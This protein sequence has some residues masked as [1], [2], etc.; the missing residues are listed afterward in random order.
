MA[1]FVAPDT[2]TPRLPMAHTH[3]M[4]LSGTALRT[5]IGL[6]AGLCFVAFGYGQGDIGGLVIMDGFR[7]EFPQIDA[8]LHPTLRVSLLTG[9]TVAMWN[10]GCFFGAMLTVFVGDLCGRK[11]SIT[12]GLVLMISGKIVQVAS[13]SWPQFLVGRFLA[14]FGNGI[15]AST[16]PA[17]QAECLKTHRRGTLLLVSFGSCITAGVAMAYWIDYGFSFVP[18]ESAS[19]RT[20]VG[21]G[22]TFMVPP[23]L[24]IVFL[25]E[26]PRYLVLT[27]REAEAKSVLSALNEDSPEDE[28]IHREFLMIKN[29][30]LHLTSGGVKEAFTMGKYRYLHRTILAVVLQ[31]M[32]QFTGVNLFIQYLGGMFHNQLKFPIPMALLLAGVCSTVFFLASLV[33]VVGIDR[34]WG[35]RTLTMFGAS[36]MCLCM[37]LLAILEHSG[38]QKAHYAMTAFLFL[39]CACFAIGWQGMS[40]LWAVELIPLCTRGPANAL[41][42]AANWLA[43]FAVVMATPAMFTNIHYRI[44]IVFAVTNFCIVPAI[45]FFYPETG[46]RSL[47]EVDVLFSEAGKAGHPWLSVV[48]TA[49][50]EPLWFDRF[51]ERSDSYIS[52]S[53]LRSGSSEKGKHDSQGSDDAAKWKTH[54]REREQDFSSGS[55]SSEGAEGVAQSEAS[56]T[57]LP[58][59]PIKRSRNGV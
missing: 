40:W 52:E 29:T 13:F 51:G 3:Y 9:I 25:P 41:A 17:W 23:L 42:T 56:L 45:Y 7:K 35:R 33:A 57:A 37:T 39:Y 2:I 16:V 22:M 5:A 15:I 24:L 53:G 20:P 4:G 44:Y 46:Y 19:W 21:L 6:T 18:A 34:F 55:G 38:T 48:K 10:L 8:T 50:M 47:E 32:Q 31:V 30:L 58:P 14:G 54:C 27:G 28:D 49:R 12:L 36:G 26:S 43:N 59:P 11:G 1:N